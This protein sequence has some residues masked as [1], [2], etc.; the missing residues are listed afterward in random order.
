MNKQD[1]VFAKLVEIATA[2]FSEGKYVVCGAL[3]DFI[4]ANRLADE[5][6]AEILAVA[7]WSEAE[8]ANTA[9]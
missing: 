5:H 6:K 9:A 1:L 3:V 8:K 4:K 7:V 2:Y